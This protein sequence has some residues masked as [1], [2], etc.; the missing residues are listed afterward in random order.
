[1]TNNELLWLF[2]LVVWMMTKKSILV[3][4]SEDCY[5]YQSWCC[6]ECSDPSY[7]ADMATCLDCCKECD[8]GS[9]I[10]VII[11]IAVG[12]VFGGVLLIA[13]FIQVC[14]KGG[15]FNKEAVD[16]GLDNA[17]RAAEGRMEA[18]RMDFAAGRV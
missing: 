14:V 10:A 5:P 6:N 9:N 15:C 13:L 2:F 18:Q 3:S 17:G 1:M 8:G 16:R 7:N 12:S 4:A 11:G